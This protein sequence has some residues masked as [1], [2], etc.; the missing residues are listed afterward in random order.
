MR[1]SRRR[2][3]IKAGCIAAASLAAPS[4]LRAAATPAYANG[5]GTIALSTAIVDEARAALERHR[6]SLLHTDVVGIA[7]FGQYCSHPRFHLVDME[8]GAID[9]LLVAHG[10]GSDPQETGWLETFS[11][12]PGSRATSQ[13]SYVTD[14]SYDGQ[15][16]PSRRVLGLDPD[17]SN[18][19]DRAIVIHP[20]EYVS[21]DLARRFG[22][23]GTSWGCF[24]FSQDDIATVLERL[25]PSRLLHACRLPPVS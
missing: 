22:R 5:H 18:A 14:E 12:M 6:A 9:S 16:G 4:W 25:G 20:A 1:H 2:D 24:A 10:E 17:N 19:Y 7:D 15:Y 11:N 8:N 23:I 13:G 3:V 21:L